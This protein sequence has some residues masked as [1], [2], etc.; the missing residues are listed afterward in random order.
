MKSLIW[1]AAVLLMLSS[2]S[3]FGQERGLE[4]LKKIPEFRDLSFKMSEDQL[5]SHIKKHGLYAK[6]DLENDRVSY[7]LLT[8]EG[9]NVFVG[10]ASGKCTGIQRMQP[11][12][13]QRIEDSIGASAYRAWMAERKKAESEPKRDGQKPAR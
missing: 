12:P 8:T 7:W 6:K 2:L 11:I 4:F 3:S 5:T 9:E 1:P 13:K 10:F